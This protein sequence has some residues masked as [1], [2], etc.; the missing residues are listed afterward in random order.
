MSS[1]PTLS[2]FNAEQHV[3]GTK[4]KKELQ[5]LKRNLDEELSEK[6]RMKTLGVILESMFSSL[7]EARSELIN[8][9]GASNSENFGLSFAFFSFAFLL[10]TCSSSR[11][12]I[13]NF[14]GK[15]SILD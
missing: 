7:V 8:L 6:E 14:T 11:L 15:N 1:T 5:F 10:R 12:L 4:R 13:G 9:K 2:F 3:E